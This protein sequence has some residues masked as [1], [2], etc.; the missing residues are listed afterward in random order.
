MT[1]Y[2]LVASAPPVGRPMCA[3]FRNLPRG[4]PRT[5]SSTRRN[6]ARAGS[7]TTP[8]TVTMLGC[9]SRR[10]TRNSLHS[11]GSFW[12]APS[13]TRCPRGIFTATA[14]PQNA[15]RH[16]TPKPPFPSGWPGNNR[17]SE[18][19]M[20]QCSASTS[21]AISERRSCMLPAV[22]SIALKTFPVAVV[23]GRDTLS[24]TGSLLCL[25]APTPSTKDSLNSAWQRRVRSSMISMKAR[26]STSSVD[27]F[28]NDETKTRP[29]RKITC[30]TRSVRTSPKAG[31]RTT[32]A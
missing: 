1:W 3:S 4:L 23:V 9:F 19:R 11:S 27:R 13:L 18:A 30:S 32:A 15:A 22:L 2:R 31:T 12:A 24:A 26:R 7:T 10:N 5:R 8:S 6:R 25:P 21:E 17:S 20:R 29:V 28:P 14:V 16:T